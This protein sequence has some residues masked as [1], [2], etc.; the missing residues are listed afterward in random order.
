MKVAED[1]RGHDEPWVPWGFRFAPYAAY[2]AA[3]VAAVVAAAT[4]VQGVYLMTVWCV[5][6]TAYCLY[7]PHHD[8]WKQAVAADRESVTKSRAAPPVEVREA[9]IDDLM[10]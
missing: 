7:L 9:G 1:M 4:L 5:F 8:R 10:G 6:M 3:G 2:V